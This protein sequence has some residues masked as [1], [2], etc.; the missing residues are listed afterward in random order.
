ME[1]KPGYD[2]EPYPIIGHELSLRG[3][4]PDARTLPGAPY[5]RPLEVRQ[6][7]ALKI[8]VKWIEGQTHG[9]HCPLA[10]INRPCKFI[11]GGCE[12]SKCRYHPD[13]PRECN[14]R[15]SIALA[16]IR[17]AMEA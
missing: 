1:S 17:K 7:E 9:G 14:C 3:D 6:A 12:P 5:V 16:E 2:P 4:Q 15:V 13:S 11:C 10:P 8:A